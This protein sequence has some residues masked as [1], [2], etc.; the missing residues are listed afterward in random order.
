MGHDVSKKSLSAI[1][2][3]TFLGT[4]SQIAAARFLSPD[5][6]FLENPEAC[7]KSPTECNLYSY[8]KNNPLTYTDPTGLYADD[9]GNLY[10]GPA[11]PNPA[12]REYIDRSAWQQSQGL[13][14]GFLGL[15][16]INGYKASGAIG[17]D[18]VTDVAFDTIATFG[19]GAVA[20]GTKSLA[21]AV[22]N[23]AFGGQAPRVFWSGGE[24]AK[25]GAE[26]LARSM[27]GKT[28][29]MT[30]VGKALESVTNPS[31]F[32]YLKPLWEAASAQF[33]RGA[34]CE[35]NAVQAASG[36][37]LQSVWTT[38]EYP[39]LKEKG[40]SIIFHTVP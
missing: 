25:N 13:P 27:G 11:N 30:P 10:A 29:E 35:V 7:V 8:A 39:I 23:H 15:A 28:L 12:A 31:T 17:K 34:T 14:Q 6:Y 33:A 16:G 36:V 24:L 37:R 22:V 21:G 2:I 5:P 38:V 4:F 26:S 19:V 32:P 3:A 20:S 18:F 9:R 1:V 40:A